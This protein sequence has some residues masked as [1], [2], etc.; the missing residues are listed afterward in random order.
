MSFGFLYQI[1][2][3][4]IIYIFPAYAA[5][6]APILFGGGYPLDLKK[7]LFGKRIFGDHKTIR[8]T[9]S[10]IIAGIIIGLIE[11]PFFHYMLFIAILLTIGAN[12]GDLFGSF[13][14]RRIGMKSGKSFPIMDQYGF[15]LFALIFALPF[16]NYPQLLGIIFI[17]ILT[18][19]MHPLTNIGANKLKLKDVPW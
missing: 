9:I 17:I 7:K 10:S 14:K 4:P 19:I 5:N 1:F 18:G 15:L 13:I 8:G 2:L 16:G 11:Y 6:G 3:Y 12:V